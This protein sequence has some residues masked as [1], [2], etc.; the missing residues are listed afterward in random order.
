MLIIEGQICTISIKN[1]SQR[2]K[3]EEERNKRI[4]NEYE[5]NIKQ[6]FDRSL[7]SHQKNTHRLFENQPSTA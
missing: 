6:E 4:K 1:D 7:M 2:E 5:I 3:I